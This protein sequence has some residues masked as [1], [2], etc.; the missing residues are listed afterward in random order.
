MMS[1]WKNQ[2]AAAS[3]SRTARCTYVKSEPP[4]AYS[5]AMQMYSEVRKT[6]LYSI[7]CGWRS[8]LWLRI[9]FS[10]YLFTRSPRSM[11]LMAT[12]S[13]VCRLRASCTKPKAPLLRSAIF[14]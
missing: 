1:C 5:M 10:T 4:E 3:L 6:S 7:T 12:S 11:N 2:R 9:S 14:S 8:I 13:S